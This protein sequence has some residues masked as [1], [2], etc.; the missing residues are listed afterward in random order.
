M[1]RT[2]M[3]Y[4]LMSWLSSTTA[5]AQPELNMQQVQV[6]NCLAEALTTPFEVLA[7]HKGFKILNVPLNELD[8]LHYAADKV[9]CGRFVNVTRKLQAKSEQERRMNAQMLLSQP[10]T[11]ALRQ[12]RITYPIQ[13]QPEV[14]QALTKV[15]DKRIE[16]TLIHLTSYTNRSSVLNNGVRTAKWLKESF[17]HLAIEYGRQDVKSYFI[18]TGGRFIQPSVVTV[19]GKDLTAPGIVIGAHMDT[20]GKAERQRMP[21]AGDD[22]SGSASIMEVARIL[23]SS[24]LDLKRPIYIIWYAAEEQGLLG[25]QA[26]VEHFKNKNIPVFAAIQFDM[27]G[28]RNDPNDQTMWVYEDYT[29]KS[30]SNFVSQLITTYV[31]VPVEYSQCGY[32]CSDHASWMAEGIPAA[33]PC[34]TS[35]EQHNPY[36]HSALDTID[37]LSTEHMA[38]FAKLGL[39]FAI[40]LATKD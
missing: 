11:K 10:K 6:P 26:V 9:R 34:E 25:S 8:T 12:D 33:F 32:G 17:D 3:A 20:L 31:N 37:L 28:F 40:E 5:I 35:F 14:Q 22:G 7:E 1:K 4:F 13:H 38:N 2:V 18:A 36:I 30:L 15:D 39:A 24:K 23:L 27:T 19:I 16:D 21:G 29:D